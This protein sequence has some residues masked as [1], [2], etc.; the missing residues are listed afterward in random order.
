MINHVAS[1]SPTLKT[2][3]PPSSALGTKAKVQASENTNHLH[4][5]WPVESVKIRGLL[6]CC[7][8]FCHYQGMKPPFY[9][10]PWTLGITSAK[11]RV[12]LRCAVCLPKMDADSMVA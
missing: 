4:I 2:C 8:F 7:I 11:T 12:F 6:V 5:H 3:A 9:H 10:Y 1:L